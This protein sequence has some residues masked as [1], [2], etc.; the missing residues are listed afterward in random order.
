[1]KLASLRP[2][3]TFFNDRRMYLAPNR[4]DSKAGDPT[5]AASVWLGKGIHRAIIYIIRRHF[6]VLA[7]SPSI[8]REINI[9]SD[10]N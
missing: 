6:N 9:H 1:M 10:D 7:Q 5:A 8:I 4:V 3:T 2:G